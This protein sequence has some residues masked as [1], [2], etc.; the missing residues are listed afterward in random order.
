MKRSKALLTAVFLVTFLM[1]G[2]GA[3]NNLPHPDGLSSI[4]VS[5]TG[6]LT[7]DLGGVLDQDYYNVDEL[8]SMARSEISEFNSQVGGAAV[9]LGDYSYDAATGRV[10]L[11]Y[12]FTG[13]GYCEKLT[14]TK[15]FFGS[16]TQA[17]LAGFDL[18]GMTFYSVKD[19]GAK[20]GSQIVSELSDRDVI[21]TNLQGAVMGPRAPEYTSEGLFWVSGESGDYCN[22]LNH[23]GDYAVILLKK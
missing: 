22:T 21:I 8:V 1:T 18:S 16:V 15:V 10:Y 6:A 12:Q 20:P 17:S 9:S 23:T 5:E 3:V 11:P 14:G 19:G 7:Y 4:I 2:C 13:T